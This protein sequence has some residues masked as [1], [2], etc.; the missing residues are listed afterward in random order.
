MVSF[1]LEAA[2]FGQLKAA[3]KR[4]KLTVSAYCRDLVAAEVE[5]KREEG[6]ADVYRVAFTTLQEIQV[7]KSAL[8]HALKVIFHESYNAPLPL[9]PAEERLPAD[10][11]ERRF[12]DP[13]RTK[14]GDLFTERFLAADET[15]RAKALD[16]LQEA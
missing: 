10:E 9:S 2:I 11:Q 6:T 16:R 15:K 5:N 4:R 13:K 12:K 1:R 8:I 7:V 3:A 14:A